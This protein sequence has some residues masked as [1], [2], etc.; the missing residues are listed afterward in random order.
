MKDILDPAVSTS[1]ETVNS[2]LGDLD[3]FT[4]TTGNE[5]M[6][7]GDIRATAAALGGIALSRLLQED[8]NVTTE[9]VKVRH[10]HTYVIWFLYF[11]MLK[12]YRL[13]LLLS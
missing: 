5:T 6:R 11:N 12:I 13:Y 4:A 8:A 2:V 3:D 9:E 10:A 1:T 7:P